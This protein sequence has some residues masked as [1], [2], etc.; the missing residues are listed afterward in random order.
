MVLCRLL[1]CTYACCSA[2]A[3]PGL[4]A[5]PMLFSGTTCQGLHVLARVGAPPA[6]SHPHFPPH[7]LHRHVGCWL[8][9]DGH[10]ADSDGARPSGGRHAPAPNSGALLGQAAGHCGPGHGSEWGVVR[11]SGRGR[12][13]GEGERGG[14]GEGLRSEGEGGKGKGRGAWRRRGGYATSTNSPVLDQLCSVS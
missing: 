11:G 14:K 7:L 1:V 10:E 4:V 12:R 3:P 6:P 8:A 9:G 13:K 5:A 2:A